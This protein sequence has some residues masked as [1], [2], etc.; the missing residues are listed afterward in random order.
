VFNPSPGGGTSAP[1]PMM[2]VDA[3]VLQTVAPDSGL[4]G[5]DIRVVLSGRGLLGCLVQAD[6]REIKVRDI[7]FAPD[8]SMLAATIAIGAE[9]PPGPALIHLINIAGRSQFNFT[10]IEDQVWPDLVIEGPGTVQLEGV[11]TYRNIL[12][13]TGA[14][15]IGSGTEA[16]QLLAT[17]QVTVYG[18]IHVSG[19]NGADG[20]FD[21]APGG[22]AGPGGSGGGG[23]ADGDSPTGASGGQGMPAGEDAAI[24][25]GV[26][27]GSGA[28]GGMGGG[29][30]IEGGCGQAGGG[31][32]FGGHG[33]NGGGDAGLGTGGAGGTANEQGSDCH[34]GV[35]GG[36]GSTCGT[37]SGG[38]GGG[39]GGVLVIATVAGGD[40]IIKG[41]LHANGGRGGAGHLVTGG[42][43]G[44]SG[45][46][47]TLTA[48]GGHILVEDVLSVRGGPGGNSYRNDGGGGGGGGRIFI[49]AGGGSVD[50]TN[51]WYDLGGGDGGLS[52][53][54]VPPDLGFDGMNGTDG[55]IDIQN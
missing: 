49:N 15:V 53:D 3:P 44:G 40:I 55:L 19:K 11:Q 26:G 52:L 51:A 13:K 18:E 29:A 36:G 54:P 39:G 24:G 17:G 2:A 8:G 4:Q 35:G 20:Y 5:Q 37:D 43:G 27:T 48:T 42:G 16:L 34:G 10:V 28:G 14:V 32:G 46:R 31:G 6:S 25:T 9:A 47:I 41:A 22:L 21:P 12:I 7:D 23:G 1:L 45:G 33:G 30:G 38:G 50:D